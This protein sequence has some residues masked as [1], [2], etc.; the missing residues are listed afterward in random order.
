MDLS[1]SGS[2]AAFKIADTTG[3]KLFCTY[4]LIRSETIEIFEPSENSENPETS[5]NPEPREY[6]QPNENT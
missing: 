1:S 5:E 4:K 2:V 3:P 6:P